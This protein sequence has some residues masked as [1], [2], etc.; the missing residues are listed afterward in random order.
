MTAGWVTRVPRRPAPQDADLVSVWDPTPAVV[1]VQG[2]RALPAKY[3]SLVL[4][5]NEINFD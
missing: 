1:I 4:K 5:L 2:T 3:V